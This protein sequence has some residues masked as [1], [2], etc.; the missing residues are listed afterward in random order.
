MLILLLRLAVAVC[1]IVS[2]LLTRVLRCPGCPANDCSAR[3]LQGHFSDTDGA[4]VGLGED[5]STVAS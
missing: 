3:R 4:A 5:S 1:I 2:F